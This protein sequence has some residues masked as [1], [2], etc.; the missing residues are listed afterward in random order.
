[1]ECVGSG[2]NS[3]KWLEMGTQDSEEGLVPDL[4]EFAVCGTA[5]TY[6][7]L[8]LALWSHCT[9]ELRPARTTWHVMGEEG[10]KA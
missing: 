3:A 8:D 5:G 7:G 9:Q 10:L 2:R 4:Q 1:M 6:Q